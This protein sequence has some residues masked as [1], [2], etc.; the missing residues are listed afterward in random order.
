[1]DVP[2]APGFPLFRGKSRV[3][4]GTG[5][6]GHEK[7]LDIGVGVGFSGGRRGALTA[8]LLGVNRLFAHIFH[9]VARLV[10][11]GA[12]G[13]QARRRARQLGHR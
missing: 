6:S 8:P 7:L 4:F 10:I 13:A 12:A 9:S 3:T 1:M 2:A 11:V 5:F